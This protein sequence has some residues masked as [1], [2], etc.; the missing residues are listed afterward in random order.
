MSDLDTLREQVQQIDKDIVKLLSDRQLLS[1]KIGQVKKETGQAIVDPE[2]EQ[3]LE[4]YYDTLSHSY[5]LDPTFLKQL[6]K[7][8]ILESREQQ[9]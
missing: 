7:L 8:I 6:F 3:A 2:R 4:N 9:K 5:S 1:K